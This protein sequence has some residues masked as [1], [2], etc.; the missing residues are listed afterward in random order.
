VSLTAYEE[1]D[2][3]NC[4]PSAET[5]SLET[6]YF[7]ILDIRTVPSIKNLGHQYFQPGCK[8]KNQ[9]VF[10]TKDFQQSMQNIW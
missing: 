4:R 5:K 7:L 3:C 1:Q 10:G 2:Y 8:E 9:H 6:A